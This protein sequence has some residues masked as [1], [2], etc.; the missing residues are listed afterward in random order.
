M[1]YTSLRVSSCSPWSTG[2]VAGAPVQRDLPFLKPVLQRAF[3]VMVLNGVDH[4]Y[5]HCKA[6]VSGHKA[7]FCGGA[8]L[9]DLHQNQIPD[10]GLLVIRIEQNE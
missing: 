8:K 7:E 3:Q 5:I 4:I 1:L 9:F 6:T 10:L 2:A